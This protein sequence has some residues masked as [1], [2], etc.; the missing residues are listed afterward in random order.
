MSLGDC[1][2]GVIMLVL[3]NI[4]VGLDD[5]E[6][7]LCGHFYLVTSF[8]LSLYGSCGF[9]SCIYLWIVVSKILTEEFFYKVL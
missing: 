1:G 8:L 9:A 4:T 2:L 5:L 3:D 7:H 6:K